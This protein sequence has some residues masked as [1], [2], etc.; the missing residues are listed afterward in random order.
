MFGHR[1]P[2]VPA[3]DVPDTAYLLDVR[4]PEEWRAGHAPGAVH[5]PMNEVPG[6][7][8]EIPREGDVVVVC[9]SGNRSA[10]VTAYLLGNGWSN[11]RNLGDGMM[12]WAA[13]GRPV[14]GTDG[15][16]GYVA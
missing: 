8:A 3:R 10:Q 6:R 2:T 5:L 14:T 11:V 7:L 13:A 16:V 4:E 15:T 9:R 1:V 12:G